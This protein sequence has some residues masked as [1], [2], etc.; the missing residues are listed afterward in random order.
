M[1][2]GSI[3]SRTCLVRCSALLVHCTV[4]AIC[5][6]QLW[7]SSGS[8]GRSGRYSLWTQ[9]GKLQSI[10]FQ[11]VAQGGYDSYLV[12]FENGSMIYSIQLDANGIIT[13]MGMRPL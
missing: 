5:D 3:H 8:S 10:Q 1:I 11:G 9:L 12:K 2:H 7:V 4:A 13:G 6:R